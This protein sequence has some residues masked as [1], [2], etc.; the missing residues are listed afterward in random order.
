M[1]MATKS[2][3]ADA[4][5]HITT[6]GIHHLTLRVSDYNRAKEFYTKILDFEIVLE[7]PN[8]FIFFAGN[9]AIAIRGPEKETPK[10][11]SFNP[12]RVGL[13]HV[14][15]ACNEESELHRVAS[16]LENA[17]VWNTGV[18]TDETLNKKYVAFKDPDQISWEYYM[19]SEQ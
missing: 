14:A 4:S 13:D 12:F 19:T 9:T 6:I 18:K 5:I 1:T 8:L 2:T 11:D 3:R 10:N 16:E 17:G 7:K 15:L